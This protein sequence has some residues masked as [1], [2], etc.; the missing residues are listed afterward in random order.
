MKKFQFVITILGLFALIGLG[1]GGSSSSTSASTDTDSDSDTTTTENALAAEAYPSDLVITS[2]TAS[3]SGSALRAALT[4][5]AAVDE[6]AGEPK[7]M[8]V[9]TEEFKPL[10]PS[11][12]KEN[13]ATILEADSE[14]GCA[15]SLYMGA[16]TGSANCYGPSVNYS[17]HPNASQQGQNPGLQTASGQLPSGD[18][19]I[20]T[21]NEASTG[22]ACIAAKL[23]AQVSEF[24]AMLDMAINSFASMM[25]VGK[26]ND[27]EPPSEVGEVLDLTEIF[28][29]SGAAPFTVEEATTTREEDTAEGNENFE[30]TLAM[31]VGMVTEGETVDLSGECTL[32]HVKLNDD[33][34]LYEGHLTCVMTREVF[35]GEPTGGCTDPNEDTLT[36]ALSIVYEKA[37]ADSLNYEVRK[38]TFCGELT[39]ADVI[40]DG[41]VNTSGWAGNYHYALFNMDP[42]TF[43]GNFEYAWQAGSGDSNTRAFNLSL[44]EDEAETVSGCGYFGYGPAVTSANLG[45]IDEFICNWAGPG[46]SHDGLLKAQRQCITKSATDTEFQSVSANLDIVYA[47]TNSCDASAGGNF[48]YTATGTPAGGTPGVSLDRSTA[49][50]AVTHDLFL[51]SNITDFTAPTA[52]DVD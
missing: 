51:L 10:P 50:T 25:C 18:L 4:R 16:P 37:T 32:D 44:T 11:E 22:E 38:A 35:P 27:Q 26:V 24:G 13:I 7:T 31:S 23:N 2:P 52:P 34:T 17:N 49:T 6:P 15:F 36:D 20:W 29:D 1:C 30:S 48:T 40:T 41:E 8:D 21:E 46:N 39:L 33:N 5:T 12:M 45:M 19:G 47:P 42:D 43:E 28:E 3:S 14:D 9:S